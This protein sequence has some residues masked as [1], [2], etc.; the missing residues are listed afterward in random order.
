VLIDPRNWPLHRPWVIIAVAATALATAWYVAA[1]LASDTWP[2]GSSAPGFTFGVAGGLIILFQMLLWARKKLRAWRLGRVQ[3]W[4]RAHI[5]LGL[6]CLPLLVLHSGFRWGGALS[7]V[8]L[9][10]LLVVIASGVWGVLLQQLLPSRLLDDAPA[11][12]MASQYD[13]VTGQLRDEAE[14][15]VLAAGEP[16]APAKPGPGKAAVAVA[17]VDGPAWAG[18][19]RDAYDAVI[20]PFLRD[21]GA[22]RSPLRHGNRAAIV[23]QD[24][25]VKLGPAAQPT[26]DG[27]EALCDQRRQL[28]HQARLHFWLHNWLLLHVPL[29][30]ALVVLMVVHVWVALKYW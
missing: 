13:R 30:V 12:A 29:S 7:T 27:L 9:V 3:A 1:G 6:L 15:L 19:L 11:E 5:W 2:G 25:R 20:E 24:L 18:H 28:D 10:L 8:L 21:G 26:L 14:R 4:L 16:A 23:F 17:T 22:G